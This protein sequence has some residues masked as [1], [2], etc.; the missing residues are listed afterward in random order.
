MRTGVATHGRRSVVV[1]LLTNAPGTIAAVAVIAALTVLAATARWVVP[2][3]PLLQQSGKEFQRPS[4]SYPFG[5][6]EFGR[7]IL[8]RIVYGARVSL[9]TAAGVLLIAGLS[10]VSLGLAS[11]YFGGWV[12]AL[13]MRFLD[14]LLAVPSILLAMAIVAVLGAGTRNLILAI[15]VVSIPAFARLSRASTLSLKE[16]D[17]VLATR[18]IGAGALYLVVRT[19]LPNAVSPLVVQGAFTA[20][21]AI[22]LEASLSFLGLGTQ[23]P[24]PSWGSMLSQGRS[25]LHHS[26]WYGLFPGM[27]ITAVVLALNRIAD[28]LQR[29]LRVGR[30]RASAR[31]RA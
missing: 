10:G 11:G 6:D 30:G 15:A 28:V 21:N 7:D 18:A 9:L 8:S 20:A 25:F 1:G 27:V 3:D 31:E 17:F 13:C 26:P 16:R 29:R 19:I 2:Y 12:D 24:Q 14:S 5:T 23:P 22:L 4:L